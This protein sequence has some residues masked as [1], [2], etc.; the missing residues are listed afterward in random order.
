MKYD[1]SIRYPSYLV[2]FFTI[3]FSTQSYAQ[4]TLTD[5]ITGFNEKSDTTIF[6][7]IDHLKNIASAPCCNPGWQSLPR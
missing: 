5:A 6:Y 1:V 3:F 4:Y 7:N 2:I